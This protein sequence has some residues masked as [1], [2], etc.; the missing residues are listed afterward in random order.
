MGYYD[1][2]DVGLGFNHSGFSDIGSKL[3][4]YPEPVPLNKPAFSSSV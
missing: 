3:I 2:P 4:L 1:Q